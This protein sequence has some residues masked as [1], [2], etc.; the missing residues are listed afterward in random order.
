M[1]T[2]PDPE[3]G[4]PETRPKDRTMR[5]GSPL[6]CSSSSR[7]RPHGRGHR[8]SSSA[9]RSG[10]VRSRPSTLHFFINPFSGRVR[11]ADSVARSIRQAFADYA[12]HIHRRLSQ[13][14][15][16]RIRSLLPSERAAGTMLVAVGGDGT[17]NRMVNLFAESAA[18]MGLIPMG[19]SN[20]LAEAL[21]IPLNF[22]EA[23]R[24]IKNACFRETDVISVNGTLFVTCGGLGLACHTARRANAWKLCSRRRLAL[25]RRLG[26]TIYPLA[27]LLQCL[28]DQSPLQARIALNGRVREGEWFTLI[29]GNQRQLGGFALPSSAATTDATLDLVA[30]ASPN[31]RARTLW[32]LLQ[33][34][35]GRLGR[36][37]DVMQERAEAI[38]ITTRDRSWFFG[39]GE[40]LER[41]RHFRVQIHPRAILLSVPEDL[42]PGPRRASQL[43]ETSHA[44]QREASHG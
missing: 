33:G 36:C 40:I 8:H 27:A 43:Q 29:I 13:E 44:G 20:D 12:V 17:V 19:T 1:N 26:K 41:A 5:T 9:I 18:P 3:L 39:D 21:G 10:P 15:V 16:A 32:I 24:V 38:T 7:R 31:S 4:V 14:V 30:V 2:G 11:N 23:C 42:K 35:R 28:T 22:D 25:V 34:M 6:T 37:S